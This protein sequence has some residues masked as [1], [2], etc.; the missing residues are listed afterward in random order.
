MKDW[1]MQGEFDADE[2]I[3]IVADNGEGVIVAELEP[4]GG[5]NLDEWDAESIARARL[6][7]AAPVRLQAL[8]KIRKDGYLSSCQ[9]A[10]E[11]LLACVAL[12]EAA[13]GFAETGK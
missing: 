7:V 2:R 10:P 3:E 11:V 8:V 4:H 13:I 1:I 6:I 12:A 5:E 9:K